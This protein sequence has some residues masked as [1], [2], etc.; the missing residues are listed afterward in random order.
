MPLKLGLQPRTIQLHFL[1]FR[2]VSADWVGVGLVRERQSS[3]CDVT[4]PGWVGG[5]AVRGVG[6]TLNGGS[7]DGR[8]GDPKGKVAAENLGVLALGTGLAWAWSSP[9]ASSSLH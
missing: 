2:M 3:S 5:V 8:G 9:T 7:T 1:D 4:G 6:Y